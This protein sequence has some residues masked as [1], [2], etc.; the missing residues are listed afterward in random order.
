MAEPRLHEE[1]S[2]RLQDLLV[3]HGV[4]SRQPAGTQLFSVG[5]ES[6]SV[7]IVEDGLLRVDRTTPSGKQV[8]VTLVAPGDVVGELSLIDGGRRSASCSVVRSARVL[9]LGEKDFLR[10]LE[11]EPELATVI[12]RRVV[13]RMRALTDQ[14]VAASALPAHERM[15]SRLSELMTIAG[16]T[17]DDVIELPLP[18]SQ[19]D[20]AHWAGLSREG[21]VKGLRELRERGVIETG[22]KH[23]SV[24]EPVT[25]RQ[26][27]R[28]ATL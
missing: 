17:G 21:A 20:L 18:I 14:L 22:R 1:I 13:R 11:S 25:L 27:A 23:V 19:Q 24:L 8:L 9:K 15:A 12:T 7:Y 5:E 10:I 28:E 2:P 4:R 6:D 16:K 26:L 3:E